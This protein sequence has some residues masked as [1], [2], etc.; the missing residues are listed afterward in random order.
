MR[1]GS[2]EILLRASD[3]RLELPSLRARRGNPWL[4]LQRC[5]GRPRRQMPPRDDGVPILAAKSSGRSA[6]AGRP[7]GWPAAS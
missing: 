6:P 5:H 2:Q 3:A 4:R 1:W 7:L